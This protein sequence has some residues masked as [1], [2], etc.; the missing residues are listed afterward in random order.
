MISW[1]D[2]IF[3]RIFSR[4]NELELGAGV[5]FLAPLSA[6]RN[7]VT[8][9]IEV[10]SDGG[11][12][13]GGHTIENA[14]VALVQRAS[15]NFVG[16][17]V[18]DVGAKS[19]VTLPTIGT[20]GLAAGAVTGVK[21]RAGTARGQQLVWDGSAWYLRAP[22]TG[23]ALADASV[24]LQFNTAGSYFWPLATNTTAIRTLTLGTTGLAA[25]PMA[26]FGAEVTIEF[27][28]A[29]SHNIVIANG[30][31]GGG[32]NPGQRR[33]FDPQR[34]RVVACDQRGCGRSTPHASAPGA[35]L[36]RNTTWHLVADIERLRQARGIDAF[37]LGALAHALRNRRHP[38]EAPQQ[39]T[40]HAEH[41]SLQ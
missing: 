38:V 35:D 29:L 2:G 40:L 31:P 34:Y 10:T 37:C 11:P 32:I 18:A 3:N 28:R 30:G 9:R 25:G 5:D 39:P 8:K 15:L 14:G 24:T 6:S 17:T 26:G 36:S 23:A 20:A 33:L 4:G 27:D 22:K 13:G 7:P 21:L 1:L 16:F 41:H 12:G 19:T